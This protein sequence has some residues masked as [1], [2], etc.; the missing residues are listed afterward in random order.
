MK[1]ST[2]FA[3][4]CLFSAFVAGS[5]LSAQPATAT[6]YFATFTGILD[7]NFYHS[8]YDP[9]DTQLG[10]GPFTATLRLIY[11]LSY[12]EKDPD[13]GEIY[14]T[15]SAADY[16]GN[17]PVD[18]PSHVF[19]GT[20]DSANPVSVTDQ[21]GQSYNEYPGNV[22]YGSL[23]QSAYGAAILSHKSLSF[24]ISSNEGSNYFIGISSLSDI[25]PTIDVPTPIDIDVGTGNGVT[26]TFTNRTGYYKEASYGYAA[27][28]ITH[29]T[30]SVVPDVLDVPEPSSWAL[31]IVGFGAIGFAS[32]GG[33]FRT[34]AFQRRR[35]PSMP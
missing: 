2:I 26:G 5:L 20:W 7:T 30:I 23:G 31:M 14:Y 12:V 19:S 4:A 8:E 1:R 16:Y 33:A 29:L 11:P 28:R 17:D 34:A 32:R 6:N 25:F 18:G 15:G 35:R 21:P 10:T 13:T 3:R 24:L 9:V 22:D 27:G